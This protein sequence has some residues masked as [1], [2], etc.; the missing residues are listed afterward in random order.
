MY[1]KVAEMPL[2]ELS[3]E[4]APSKGKAHHA[5]SKSCFS[6]CSNRNAAALN[7]DMIQGHSFCS[8]YHRASCYNVTANHDMRTESEEIARM[9]LTLSPYRKI[10]CDPDPNRA[11]A[12][13]FNWRPEQNVSHAV[14]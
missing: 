4:V 11:A 12:S 10:Y 3:L 1:P 8:S 6:G 2:R 13:A 5:H 9:G 7:P 14:D